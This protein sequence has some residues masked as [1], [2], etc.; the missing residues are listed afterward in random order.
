M[1]GNTTTHMLLRPAAR[2][3]V[4]ST[5]LALVARAA[6]LHR[7]GL[8]F[9]TIA[10][11]LKRSVRRLLPAPA[12]LRPVRVVHALPGRQN[13][14]WTIREL[15]EQLGLPGR[16]ATIGSRT[17]AYAAAWSGRRRLCEIGDG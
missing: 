8:A 11:T 2:V 3:K 9:A 10:M 15:A 4:L 6:T 12:S 17:A 1:A 13:D 7:T 16:C 5:Y 14:E